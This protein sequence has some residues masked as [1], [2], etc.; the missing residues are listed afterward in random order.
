[1][2]GS[3]GSVSDAP[4][5]K[6]VSG[7]RHHL[8]YITPDEVNTLVD[9]GGVPT[10]TNEGVM[11]YPVLQVLQVHLDLQVEELHLKEAEEIL[12]LQEVQILVEIMMIT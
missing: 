4:T 6:T 8:A 1:M 7:Q 11:A 2:S 10:M 9:Q 3:G 5:N 12:L